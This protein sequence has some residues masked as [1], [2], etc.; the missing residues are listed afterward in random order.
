MEPVICNSEIF[1]LMIFTHIVR[2]FT[3]CIL[4]MTA[5]TSRIMLI[6]PIKCIQLLTVL[7]RIQGPLGSNPDWVSYWY[8]SLP[9]NNC[10]DSA[11]NYVTSTSIS[12]IFNTIPI[13]FPC[14]HKQQKFRALYWTSGFLYF[15][16]STQQSDARSKFNQSMI[17]STL[18]VFIFHSFDAAQS[19]YWQRH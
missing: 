2:S 8:P 3:Q 1:G 11:L 15:H 6:S 19:R 18:I 7:I 17:G 16:L 4:W 10:W 5:V 12:V 14:E 9:V 13:M